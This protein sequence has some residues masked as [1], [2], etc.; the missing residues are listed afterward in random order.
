MI[1]IILIKCTC[2]S[3]HFILWNISFFAPSNQFTRILWVKAVVI[4]NCIYTEL[5]IGSLGRYLT[6]DIK[7]PVFE[8]TVVQRTGIS[9][10]VGFCTHRPHNIIVGGGGS[11]ILLTDFGTVT[12]AHMACQII[13]NH[14]FPECSITAHQTSRNTLLAPRMSVHLG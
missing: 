12:S 11:T 6:P 7:L 1:L 5:H 3:L 13:D 8:W 9:S 4:D 10:R 14:S 2:P